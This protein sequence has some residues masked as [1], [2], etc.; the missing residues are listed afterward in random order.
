MQIPDDGLEVPDSTADRVEQ[1]DVV[2]ILGSDG[3]ILAE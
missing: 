1:A 2:I 3:V